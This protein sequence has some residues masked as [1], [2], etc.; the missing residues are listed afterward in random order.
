MEKEESK[1]E[2][3]SQKKSEPASLE[4]LEERKIG[5]SDEFK[6]VAKN[7]NLNHS[8]IKRNTQ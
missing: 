5:S 6:H 7:E 1:S 2:G 8:S 4:H 3:K